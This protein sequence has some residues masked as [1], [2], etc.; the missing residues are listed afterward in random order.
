MTVMTLSWVIPVYYRT[1][2]I[3]SF[4]L[5]LFNANANSMNMITKKTFLEM[6]HRNI[7]TSLKASN[8]QYSL[9]KLV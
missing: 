5:E 8:V 9:V 2:R 3:C 1:L 6:L 7:S 4:A